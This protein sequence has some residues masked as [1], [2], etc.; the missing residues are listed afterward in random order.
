MRLTVFRD[1]ERLT[2]A[3]D[4]QT[5]LE[6]RVRDSGIMVLLASP[7]SAPTDVLDVVAVDSSRETALVITQGEGPFSHDR[8]GCV[9]G[10]NQPRSRRFRPD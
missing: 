9:L 7:V 2:A 8:R 1:V 4:L 3:V 10:G 5:T 6:E